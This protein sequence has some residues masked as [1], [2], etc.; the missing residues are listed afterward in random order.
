MHQIEGNSIDL[1]PY[2]FAEILLEMPM[3]VVS[4]HAY[5]HYEE[6]VV[7]LDEEEKKESNPFAKLKK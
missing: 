4:P 6:T 2:V 5:D 3:K 7:T 1:D